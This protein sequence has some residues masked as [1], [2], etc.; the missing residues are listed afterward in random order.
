MVV[1]RRGEHNL[2]MLESLAKMNI[3]DLISLKFYTTESHIGYV[4]E[5]DMGGASIL[6][7]NGYCYNF[8][9]GYRAGYKA[10][11]CEERILWLDGAYK[12]LEMIRSGEAV[13]QSL[14]L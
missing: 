8:L 10:S 2:T 13:V 5:E 9:K 1:P 7:S 11:T 14:N 12:N 4:C 6:L 3:F